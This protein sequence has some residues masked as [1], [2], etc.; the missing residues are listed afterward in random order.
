MWHAHAAMDSVLNSAGN[1]FLARKAKREMDDVGQGFDARAGRGE[2]GRSTR[3]AGVNMTNNVGTS[4]SNFWSGLV[5]EL[6]H[7]DPSAGPLPPAGTPWL[8]V[9]GSLR[10]GGGG[11]AARKTQAPLTELL[12]RFGLPKGL[13]P[14]NYSKYAFDEVAGDEEGGG[15]L[16]VTLPYACEVKFADGSLVRYD[17]KVTASLMRGALAGVDG[18]KMQW[19]VWMAVLDVAAGKPG[20]DRLVFTTR[21]KLTKSAAA[22]GSPREA[23]ECLNWRVAAGWLAGWLGSRGAMAWRAGVKFKKRGGREV[24]GGAK[25]DGDG[26]G[27]WLSWRSRSRTESMAVHT[28]SSELLGCSSGAGSEPDVGLVRALVGTVYKDGG[29]AADCCGRICVLGGSVPAL[30]GLAWHG[31]TGPWIEVLAPLELGGSAGGEE[32]GTSNS[33][34]AGGWLQE[35]LPAL[36]R[37]AAARR[38]S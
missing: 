33:P 30:A 24:E 21:M 38:S 7:P 2:G 36:H 19:G 32:V 17:R 13:F 35:E 9:K 14:K 11:S 23:V 37:A 27:V 22:F 3:P 8:S 6:S 28:G 5:G 29:E 10:S 18:M 20:S 16:T 15:V 4:I 1:W 12:E 26:D 34:S 31:P 25:G